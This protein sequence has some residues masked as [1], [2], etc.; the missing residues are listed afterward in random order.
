MNGKGYV[1]FLSEVV[2]FDPTLFHLKCFSAFS[3][4]VS[5]CLR[6]HVKS[7]SSSCPHLKAVGRFFPSCKSNGDYEEWQCNEHYG[8]CWCV[9]RDGNEI[10]GTR[11]KGKPDC[12][13]L[14]KKDGQCRSHKKIFLL[15]V[16]DD[17]YS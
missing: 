4:P 8:V 12:E 10:P 14:G 13:K 11:Q 2:K 3:A 15:S 16:K 7:L 1:F 5:N 17:F 6:E 9:D